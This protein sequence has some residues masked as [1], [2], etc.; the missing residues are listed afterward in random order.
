MHKSQE[1]RGN[2]RGKDHNGC[3]LCTTKEVNKDL[4]DTEGAYETSLVVKNTL[5]A[6]KK[7]EED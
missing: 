1:R 3:T 6:W 4:N 5:N 2:G 7:E